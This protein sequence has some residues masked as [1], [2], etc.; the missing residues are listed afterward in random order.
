MKPE[1]LFCADEDGCW[2]VDADVF[3]PVVPA[4]DVFVNVVVDAAALVPLA[5]LVLSGKPPP[6]AVFAAV[7]ID[8]TI[9]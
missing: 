2:E 1:P 8:P 7:R 3:V 5:P 9:K 4:L 6:N